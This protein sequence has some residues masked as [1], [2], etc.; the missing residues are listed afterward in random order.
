MYMMQTHMLDAM[1]ISY[2]TVDTRLL[3]SDAGRV[4]TVQLTLCS[5]VTAAYTVSL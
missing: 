4:P 2:P 1:F 3:E 5:L